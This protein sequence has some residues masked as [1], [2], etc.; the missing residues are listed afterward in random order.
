MG[1]DMK[2]L[3]IVQSNLPD[4]VLNWLECD[5]GWKI[6]F[7]EDLIRGEKPVEPELIFFCS[8]MDIENSRD[9]YLEILHKYSNIPLVVFLEDELFEDSDFYLNNDCFDI[10][11]LELNPGMFRLIWRKV[12]S[13]LK[14]IHKRNETQ[15]EILIYETLLNLLSHDTRNL[16]VKLKSIMD[17]LETGPVKTMLHDGLRELFETIMSAVGYLNDNRRILSL[18]EVVYNLKLTRERI[19]LSQHPRIEFKYDDK[20]FLFAEI[21]ELFKHAVLNIVENA[22]KYSDDIVQVDITRH[23]EDIQIRVAD[24]GIGINEYEKKQVFLRGYRTDDVGT[25]EGS[26]KGLWITRNI[27]NKDGGEIK[28]EDNV[29]SGTVFI[30]TIPAF[31]TDNIE[32][33]LSMILEGFDVD[34]D[35][36]R[37]IRQ[38]IET[39]IALYKPKK[40]LD[41]DSLV[42]ANLLEYMRK[43]QKQRSAVHFRQKLKD[44]KNMNPQGKTV[45]IVDD[46]VYVHYYLGNYL[47]DLG[48]RIVEYGLNGEEAV[49][50]Y[51]KY[52]PDIVTLDITMPVMSGLE[53]SQHI[54]KENK[55]A[56]IIFL[57]GLGNHG[58]IIELLKS[59]LKQ[60]NYTVLA[61]PFNLEELK[62]ALSLISMQS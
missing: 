27:V 16:F 33:S 26:G 13:R 50:Y 22:L 21:S 58:A 54:I 25:V 12:I 2:S 7:F 48:F 24:H 46:S 23:G 17:D 34:L 56:R 59:R 4:Q 62:S 9:L 42:F 30:I 39:L 61:K 11:P 36:L 28:V 14:G 3:V 53:A 45:L 55:D 31:F 51:K 60:N 41:F 1:T 15:K 20:I 8:S 38:N 18:F 19:P 52:K 6:H 49:T 37:Q 10:F 40:E 43:E 29:H 57:S 5:S 32:D 47:T 44:F 35:T